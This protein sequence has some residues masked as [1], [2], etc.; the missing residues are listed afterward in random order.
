VSR[1]HRPLAALAMVA[2]IMAGCSN[3]PAED[4]NTAT[5]GGNK[6]T[7]KAVRF[8]ECMRDHGVREFPDPD[9]SGG[10]TIDGVVNG[11]SL[12]TNTP[13]WKE[14]IGACKDLQP[15]GF[16]GTKASAE[17]QEVRLRFAQCMR[18]NGVEDFPDPT[19]DGP[20]IDTTRIPSAAGRGALSIPGFQAATEKCGD[21]YSGRLG[22]R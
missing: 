14:A 4:E 21:V 8:A 2:L 18:D 7:T 11:S 22:L 17:E 19:E 10:L 20:L 3:A 12:D 1:R 15:P 16:T 5:G 13:A 9:A 6:N